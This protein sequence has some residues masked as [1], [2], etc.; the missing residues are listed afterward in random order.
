MRWSTFNNKWSKNI[1]N[2]VSY[3][4]YLHYETNCLCYLAIFIL[5]LQKYAN[6]MKS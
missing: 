4:N 2:K 3:F 1:Q 6:S 5:I